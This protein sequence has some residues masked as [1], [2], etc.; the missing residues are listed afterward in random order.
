MPR[1]ED[2]LFCDG[3]GAEVIWAP[4]VSGSHYFCCQDC[5]DG[6]ECSCGDRM[7]HDDERGSVRS[8]QYNAISMYY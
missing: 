8:E 4:V 1:I 6:L 3:C 2:T 7:E 5:R